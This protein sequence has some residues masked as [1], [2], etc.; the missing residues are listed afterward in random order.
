MNVRLSFV[1]GT[2]LSI[3]SKARGA[4]RVRCSA[5]LF[6]LSCAGGA[7]C[8]DGIPG[9]PDLSRNQRRALAPGEYWPPAPEA[10][11]AGPLQRRV[12]RE[13]PEFS[14][15]VACELPQVVFKDEEQTGA[16]RLMTPRL[17]A[18][19]KRLAR[20]VDRRWPG[21]RL[22]VTEA[23]DEDGEHS[24]SSLHYEGRAVDLTTSDLDRG[25]LGE[26]AAMAT[27]AGFDWVYFE[28]S[29]VHASVRRD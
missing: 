22:R 28:R 21:M 23:W 12:E 18:R 7:A 10:E 26:L 29:H 4:T 2:A 14:G 5:L 3:R 17:V 27:E 20:A 8:A 16:D 1:F 6:A 9:G 15:L 11:T 19:M 25:K 13:H 24:A